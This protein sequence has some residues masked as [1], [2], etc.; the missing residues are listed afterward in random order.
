MSKRPYFSRLLCP[1]MPRQ[2]RIIPWTAR[3]KVYQVS[4]E[5]FWVWISKIYYSVV[6]FWMQNVKKTLGN[7]QHFFQF[8]RQLEKNVGCSRGLFFHVSHPNLLMLETVNQLT[9]DILIKGKKPKYFQFFD[10]F[11]ILRYFSTL[12]KCR[13]S[14]LKIG[15]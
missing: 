5:T 15:N 3:K 13:K 10:I 7:N 8:I 6:E 1:V 12:K 14:I 2:G 4:L 11:K 9:I